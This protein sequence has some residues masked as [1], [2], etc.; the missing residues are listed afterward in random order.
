MHLDKGTQRTRTRCP[1]EQRANA[2][3]SMPEP[4]A[5]VRE[6]GIR[7]DLAVFKVWRPDACGRSPRPSQRLLPVSTEGFAGTRVSGSKRLHLRPR[8]ERRD[9]R[10]LRDGGAVTRDFSRDYAH[11]A[12]WRARAKT[13]PRSDCEKQPVQASVTNAGRRRSPREIRE[14]LVVGA[15]AI[16][17]V[18][19]GSSD[20]PMAKPRRP[21]AANVRSQRAQFARAKPGS[22]LRRQHQPNKLG[23]APT[24]SMASARKPASLSLDTSRPAITCRRQS[25]ALQTAVLS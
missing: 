10:S 6:R 1:N 16:V 14:A 9:K 13:A 2:H 3:V 24:A 12:P 18:A 4:G 11:P 19:H 23:P 8:S 17:A 15:A 25:L 5:I 22:Q 7:R 20:R 21:I